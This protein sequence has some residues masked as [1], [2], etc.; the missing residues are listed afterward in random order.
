[1]RGMSTS[2]FE[3]ATP[4]DATV[5]KPK[6]RYDG[7]TILAVSGLMVVAIVGWTTASLGLLPSPLNRAAARTITATAGLAQAANVAPAL[8]S[9]PEAAP[10]TP[11][12]SVNE[13]TTRVAAS[14]N[15]DPVEPRSLVAPNP[16]RQV[17]KPEGPRP[18]MPFTAHLSD[19]EKAALNQRTDVTK[20][21]TA[22][23]RTHISITMKPPAPAAPPKPLLAPKLQPQSKPGAKPPLSALEY[24]GETELA[25]AG[26]DLSQPESRLWLQALL[27]A[28]AM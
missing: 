23:G 13:R 17:K 10:A 14:L 2:Q 11:K 5:T 6:G 7:I 9:E 18:G 8:R 3:A 27:A 4:T 26:H 12:E 16:F 20:S 25:Y 28:S 15:R 19:S 24:S 1:M 22:D 21:R